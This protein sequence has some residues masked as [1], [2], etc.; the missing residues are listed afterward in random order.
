MITK[1]FI[2]YFALF[3][4][5]STLLTTA[6]IAQDTKLKTPRRDKLL[7]GL[8]LVVW[9]KPGAERTD[10]KLRIHR[11]A[12]F[13]QLG[14]EGTMAMLAKILFP[15]ESSR[16]FFVEDL[17]G[18][19]EII[20]T[21]D[22]LQINASART[23]KTLDA[24]QSLANAVLNPQIDKETTGTVRTAQLEIVGELEKDPK[25]LA[26][27]AVAERLLGNFPYGR[28]VMGTVDSLKA[29]DFADLILA[30]SRFLTSDNATLTISGDVRSDLMLRAGSRYFGSWVKADEKV[31]ATF[32]VP[33]PP[34]KNLKIIESPVEDTSE[35]RFALRG[36]ARNDANYFAAEILQNIIENRLKTTDTGI[37]SVEEFGNQLAGIII[38]RVSDWNLGIIHR[39]DGKISLPVDF[40]KKLETLI[41]TAISENEF[42]SAKTKMLTRFNEQNLDRLWLDIDSYGLSSFTSDMQAAQ[43]TKLDDV[44]KLAQKMK[45]QPFASVL[46]FQNPKTSEIVENN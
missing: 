2:R 38:I 9:S 45:N 40:D 46:L 16:D 24:L 25:Y 6:A 35:L 34:S 21:Y 43:Q 39:G 42:N 22:Y 15:N 36:V 26:D 12:A 32:R 28:P 31:P 44:R 1:N 23:E 17:G 3:A 33:D 27:R 19:L 4:L 14:K 7:N 8:N 5:L 41:G 30:K 10:I 18:D 13:D 11:G 20:T 37:P 29:I